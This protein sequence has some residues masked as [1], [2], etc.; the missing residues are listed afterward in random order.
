MSKSQVNWHLGGPYSVYLTQGQV[1]WVF[2]YADSDKL[3]EK[4]FTVTFQ[5][6]EV[7]E[8]EKSSEKISD[9]VRKAIIERD[10]P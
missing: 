1:S 4:F 3:P 5:R 2:E 10:P 7:V 9:G 8:I 6:G